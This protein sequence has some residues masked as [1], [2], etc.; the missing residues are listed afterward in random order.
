[1]TICVAVGDRNIKLAG[2]REWNDAGPRLSYWW[3]PTTSAV[4]LA[5]H[6]FDLDSLS[7]KR[8]L[9]VGC[10]LGLT[11][12][13]AGLAG[14]NVAFMDSAPAAVDFARYN[15]SLNGLPPGRGQ[16][17]ISD[18]EEGLNTGLFDFI[19]GS[20]ILYDYFSHGALIQA[21]Q[22]HL[23]ANGSLILADRKRLCVSRFL[24][25]LL[26]KGFVCQEHILRPRL[27]GF[28]SQEIGLFELKPSESL[29][30]IT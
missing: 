26:G 10:G 24:G 4:A 21:I 8:V 9:D 13:A 2:P 29:N 7:G 22:T 15:A 28:P 27:D 3:Q 12:I 16:F 18:W 25:R 11:G 6:V 20:E 1:M 14:A 30:E 17:L 23:A 19:V 5:R